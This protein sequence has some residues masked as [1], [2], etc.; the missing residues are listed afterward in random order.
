MVSVGTHRMK[1]MIG[2]VLF[3]AMGVGAC[4]C[5]PNSDCPV[6]TPAIVTTGAY[7]LVQG[8]PATM[9]NLAVNI[10]AVQDTLTVSYAEG[11]KNY[12]KTYHMVRQ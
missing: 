9:T 3:A 10:D 5:S 4:D 11:G 6:P 12:V 7:A 2:L 1:R 8:Q